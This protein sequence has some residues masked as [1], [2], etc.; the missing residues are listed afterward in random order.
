[1]FTGTESGSE[2]PKSESR[3][4]VWQKDR[5]SNVSP[6]GD[7]TSSVR[8]VSWQRGGVGKEGRKEGRDNLGGMDWPTK[9]K[10][11]PQGDYPRGREGNGA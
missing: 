2:I 7:R 10:K 5:T 9:T 4:G 3:Y 11:R 1:M 6:W 8:W